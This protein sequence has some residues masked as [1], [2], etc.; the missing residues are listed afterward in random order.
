M[1]TSVDFNSNLFLKISGLFCRAQMIEFPI[2]T[3]SN[4]YPRYGLITIFALIIFKMIF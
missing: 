4:P 2:S 3:T 1:K